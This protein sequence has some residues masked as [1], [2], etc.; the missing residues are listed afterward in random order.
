MTI[1]G[2][3]ARTVAIGDPRRVVSSAGRPNA[4]HSPARVSPKKGEV[5][6]YDVSDRGTG[7]AI[8]AATI[9]IIAGCFGVLQGIALIA[10]GTFYVQPSNYW[11]T[12]G[13]ATWGWWQLIVG[14]VVIAAGVGVLSAATW[15]RWLGIVIVSVQALTN[16]LFIPAQPFWAITVILIDVW[17]IHSLFVFRRVPEGVE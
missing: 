16:F 3:V 8:F 5:M 7:G 2:T 13:A 1:V 17:V 15:A 11:I 9:M 14:A 10:K 6:S 12:T 4:Y